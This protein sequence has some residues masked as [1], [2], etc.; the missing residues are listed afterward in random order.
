MPLMKFHTLVDWKRSQNLDDDQTFGRIVATGERYRLYLEMIRPKLPTDFQRLLDLASLHDGEVLGIEIEPSSAKAS[1]WCRALD[2]FSE[3]RDGRYLR[4]EYHG[5]KKFHSVGPEEESFGGD[6][7]GDIGND[8]IEL[9]SDGT[10]EHRFLFST[11]IELG[12][13]F[14]DFK[15]IELPWSELRASPYGRWRKLL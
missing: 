1:L 14:A 12:L 7:Y 8:E 13:T 5:L 15:F 9:L 10:F 11:G 4:L 3:G 2:N 6:G